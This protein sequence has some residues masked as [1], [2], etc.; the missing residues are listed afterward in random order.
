[1]C[2]ALDLTAGT[3]LFSLPQLSPPRSL[4]S[5]LTLDG[6]FPACLLPLMPTLLYSLPCAGASPFPSGELYPIS[7]CCVVGM[8]NP[9][10]KAYFVAFGQVFQRVGQFQGH[11]SQRTMGRVGLLCAL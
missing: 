4:S 1:M 9:A 11:A 6:T 10:L 7:P 3:I 2:Q 8:R 5:L